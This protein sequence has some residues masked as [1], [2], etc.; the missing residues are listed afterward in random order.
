[1]LVQADLTLAQNGYLE[2][3]LE[4]VD[5]GHSYH[6]VNI[7]LYDHPNLLNTAVDQGL[8]DDQWGMVK[9]RGFPVGPWYLSIPAVFHV[10][11]PGG[12][13]GQ[14]FILW[15]LLFA[16]ILLFFV[17]LV[18]GVRDL[19]RYLKLYRFIY[20]YPTPG[21]LEKPELRERFGTTHGGVEA[22]GGG[23]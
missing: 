3:Y 15:N 1:M 7:W 8:T 23:K 6:L 4:A 14:G 22:V 18:P 12:A 20:R 11:F 16:A 17:P 21:E 10:Y 9:E 13:T 2:Q 19:P 5:S